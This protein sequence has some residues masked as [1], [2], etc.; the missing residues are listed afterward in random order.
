MQINKISISAVRCVLE[1]IVFCH[2]HSPAFGQIRTGGDLLALCERQNYPVYFASC[3]SYISGS[4][5]MH[6]LTASPKNFCVPDGT[7]EVTLVNV[8]I[9]RMISVEKERS[10]G[11]DTALNNAIA[12]SFPC[13]R[14]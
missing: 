9:E 6:N 2:F 8:F 4:V 12:T 13:H 5:A 11:A 3:L 1:T 7:S 14:R 10:Y